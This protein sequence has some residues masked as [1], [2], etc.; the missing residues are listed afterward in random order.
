MKYLL[1][2]VMAALCTTSPL[3]AQQKEIRV[4]GKIQLAD[5]PL[6]GDNGEIVVL[7]GGAWDDTRTILPIDRSDHKSKLI[8]SKLYFLPKP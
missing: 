1:T 6:F 3:G 5:K 8:P 2:I 7:Q 4:K